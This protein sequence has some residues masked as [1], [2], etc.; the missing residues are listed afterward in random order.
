[1]NKTIVLT[2]GGTAGHVTPN[3]ALI[4]LLQKDGWEIHYIGSYNGMER[5]LIEPLRGV[6]YHGIASGKLRRYFSLK[7]LTDPF[8]VLKGA[9]EAKKLLRKIQPDVVFAKGGFV[10]VPVAFAAKAC[11]V[12]LVLH[13][14]DYTCGLANRLC[15]PRAQ[16]VCV[17]FEPTLAGVKGGK[18]VWTGS[19]IRAEIL[20]GDADRAQLF[21]GFEKPEK[22]WILFMGGSMGSAALNA[23]VKEAFE[24]LCASYN[25]VH[26]RGK[27]NLDPTLSDPSYRQYEYVSEQMADLYAASALSV[28]R[29][30]ANTCFELLALR[31][32]S[33][34]VPLPAA[35]SRGDQILN[36]QFFQKNGYADILYQ[37]DITAQTLLRAIET[38]LHRAPQMQAAM[39]ASPMKNGTQNVLEQSVRA[40]GVQ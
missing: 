34:L 13:E 30:G 14:S 25:I 1:M 12:P 4:P 33:V 19:P 35:N 5:S 31:E 3:M 9:G 8:R 32:P 21:C 39:A 20:Q 11:H 40:A 28:C 29:A 18:G 37:E 22:P 27:N 10:C 26:I 6:T 16:T 17:S 36:A 2:G 24:A 38:A 15:A 7:N 23:A